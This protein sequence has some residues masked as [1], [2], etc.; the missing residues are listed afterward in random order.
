MKRFTDGNLSSKKPYSIDEAVRNAL[1]LLIGMYK[2]CQYE[3]SA[4]PGHRATSRAGFFAAL[5]HLDW[6]EEIVSKI[7]ETVQCSILLSQWQERYSRQY[8]DVT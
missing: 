5:R 4:V 3:R 1:T 2:Y 6:P 7:D 8:W